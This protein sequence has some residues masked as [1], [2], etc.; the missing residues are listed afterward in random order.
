M[1]PIVKGNENAIYKLPTFPAS[2]TPSR[3]SHC[4]ATLHI[5]GFNASLH[6]KT[7]PA[8]LL[9]Y[10]EPGRTSYE[11]SIATCFSPLRRVC[12]YT[13]VKGFEN[14]RV[15]LSSPYSIV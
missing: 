1:K 8:S 4:T 9:M 3:D 7:A 15:V 12:L 14:S 11:T 13:C 6:C 10:F 2:F 5:Y